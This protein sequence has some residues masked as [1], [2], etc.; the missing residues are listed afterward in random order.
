MSPVQIAVVQASFA[1]APADNLGRAESLVRR[2][3]KDGAKIILLPELFERPYFCKTQLAQPLAWAQAADENP[4]VNRL[5]QVAAELQVV[6]PVSFYQRA[7]P[8]RFNALAVADADGRLAGIR[9]KAHIPDGPGYQEKFYF[10]PGDMEFR[11]VPTRVASVGAAVCWDQWFPEC[12]RVLALRG[13]D[14]LLYPTAIGDEPHRPGFNS[15]KHWENAMRGH[16]AASMIPLAA[17]NRVGAESQ[18]DA[19]GNE[20]R[21][22]FYGGS[23]I[24]GPDGEVVARLGDEDD[25]VACAEFDFAEIA[26]AR[27]EWGIFRDRRPDL[28]RPLATLDGEAPDESRSQ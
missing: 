22:N 15:N 26:A 20:V 2:A 14:L 13:A 17:A 1:G 10:S 6:L 12:A 4:A 7:G 5:R 25:A 8:A 19:L 16:A 27:A 28:Y 24:A 9:R 23:F 3:A 21:M 18:R 11:P